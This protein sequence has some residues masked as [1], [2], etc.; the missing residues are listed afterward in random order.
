MRKIKWQNFIIVSAAACMLAGCSQHTP[1]ETAAK[2]T[3][4]ETNK[5]PE[6]EPDETESSGRQG[7]NCSRK[8]SILSR[9]KKPGGNER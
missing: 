7:R 5:E 4:D 3:A 1:I 9:Y 6:M 2:I 8:R